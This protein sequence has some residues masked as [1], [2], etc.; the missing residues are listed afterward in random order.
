VG[1]VAV[2]VGAAGD[3]EIETLRRVP[4][5]RNSIGRMFGVVHLERVEAGRRELR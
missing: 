1:R 5:T 2:K 3:R 4:V